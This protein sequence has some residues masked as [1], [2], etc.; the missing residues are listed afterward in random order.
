MLKKI[1]ITGQI[2]TGKTRALKIFKKL[3]AYTLN[4]DDI[5]HFLLEKNKN[6]KLQATNFFGKEILIQGK[7]SRQKLAKIVFDNEKKLAVLEKI[8]HPAVINII[9]KEYSRTKNKKFTF[10]VV[11]M[12]LLFEIGA[13]K[14]F[15][16]I[17]C[18]SAKEEIAKKRYKYKDY[19]SRKKRLMSLKEKESLSNFTLTNNQTLS[20]LEKKIKKVSQTIN[21]I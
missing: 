5:V 15:D 16:I 19:K 12:P 11:E 13:Q 20:D 9:A 18:I 6:I 17:I 21:K 14:Y 3:G 2:G 7:I 8:I 1:A 4:A 10:F